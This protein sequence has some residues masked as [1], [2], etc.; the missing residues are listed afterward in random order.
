LTDSFCWRHPKTSGKFQEISAMALT[1]VK[2]VLFL[3]IAFPV[4]GV[5]VACWAEGE[6][7]Y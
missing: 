6:G 7:K 1:V 5:A 4:I 3:G 2:I